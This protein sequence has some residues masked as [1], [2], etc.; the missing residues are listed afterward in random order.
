MNRRTIFF[1]LSATLL[2]C[3]I[4]TAASAKIKIAAGGETREIPSFTRDGVE[5]MSLVSLA[6]VV[7]GVVDWEILGHQISYVTAGNRFEFLV[8]SPFFRLNDSLFNLIYET[9]YKEGDLYLPAETFLP[10]VDRI[11]TERIRVDEKDPVARRDRPD[12][13]GI[14]V[15]DISFSAKANGLLVEIFLSDPLSYDVFVTEGNWINVSIRS[16]KLNVAGIE[17]RFD[18]RI[19]VKLQAIQEENVAQISFQVK[20]ALQKVK[21][22]HQK[23]VQEPTRIQIAVPDVTFKL[24]SVASTVAATQD[25]VSTFDGTIDVIVVDAGHGGK[26]YGAIGPDKTREKDVCLAM[27]RELADQIREDGRFKVIMTRNSDT[28]LTL[29][30]RADIA[31]RAGADLFISVHANASPSRKARGWNVFFLAPAK[32]DSAR[33][34]EQLENS[35]FIREMQGTGEEETEQDTTSVDTGIANDDPIMGI[36]NEMLMT[37][38]QAESHELAMMID[39][40]FRR[41]LETPARG[42]DQAGFF[43]LNKVFTPSVLVETAFISNRTEVKLLKSPAYQKKVASGIYAAIKEFADKYNRPTDLQ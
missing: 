14:N 1:L 30:E 24:D 25:P 12:Q 4:A 6:R 33:A 41:T 8:G 11:S 20:Q 2:I 16:G 29:Q 38:F 36:L 35:Y 10:F 23:L 28:Y 43:V 21:T 18:P 26:D 19:L 15:T 37:E 32:N 34:V 7:P 3:V 9:Q 17:S 31:N 39:K 13:P 27:A 40:Q 42:V 22:T 5:Y